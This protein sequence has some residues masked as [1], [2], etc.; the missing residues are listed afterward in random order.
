MD[1]KLK[2]LIAWESNIY[3][4]FAKTYKTNIFKCAHSEKLASEKYDIIRSFLKWSV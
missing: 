2:S 1:T 3:D 4:A